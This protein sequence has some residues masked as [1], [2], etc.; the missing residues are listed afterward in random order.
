MD[1]EADHSEADFKVWR[2]FLES[3][4]ILFPLADI[5]YNDVSDL[6]NIFSIAENYTDFKTETQT[7]GNRKVIKLIGFNKTSRFNNSPI[8]LLTGDGDF[9]HI[10]NYALTLERSFPVK[11]IYDTNKGEFTKTY[12]YK[13]GKLTRVAYRFT[14]LE[15]KTNTLTKRF[16]Y[17]RLTDRGN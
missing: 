13:D 12:S 7:D 5:V 8:S 11:E 10:Q 1:L 15:N 16:Q 17:H 9:I 14:N 2:D 6:S 3:R 4:D